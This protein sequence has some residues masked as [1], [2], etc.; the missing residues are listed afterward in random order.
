MIEVVRQ[1]LEQKLPKQL[2]SELLEAYG[3]VKSNYYLNKFRPNEVE[4]GRFCEAAFRILEEQ[5]FGKHTSIGKQLD[6]EKL[7]ARLQNIPFGQQS[8]SVRLHLPRTLRL[9]YDIRN[10]RDAAHLADGIDPNPQ[11]ATFVV[12]ACDWV[13]AELV[14]LYHSISPQEAQ[15]IVENII[16]RKSLVV[17]DFDGFLKTLKPSWG[18]RERLL[19]TLYQRGKSGATPEE[20][21]SWLK[22]SQRANINR[23]LGYLEHE[24]DL[25]I[26]KDN[27]YM[28]TNRGIKY[29]EGSGIL[30]PE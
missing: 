23:T 24:N 4:G 20:L 17:Q 8:E 25:I 27:L 26:L 3:E 18:P 14:R 2:V 12:A 21:A 19:A 7:I 30:T 9:I 11:D 10:K 13:L 6:T 22:P 29:V 16:E 15:K 1:G 28:I 5:A